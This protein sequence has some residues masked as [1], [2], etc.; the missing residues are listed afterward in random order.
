M[1]LVSLLTAFGVC[2]TGDRYPSVASANPPGAAIAGILGASA[3]KQGITVVV[4]TVPAQTG[5]R[6]RF[7]FVKF[8]QDGTPAGSVLIGEDGTLQFAHKTLFLEGQLTFGWVEAGK[9]IMIA[10]AQQETAS[11]KTLLVDDP[12]EGSIV[13]FWLGETEAQPQLFVRRCRYVDADGKPF[14][15]GPQYDWLYS[16]ALDNE[17]PRLRGKVCVE[18]AERRC[19]KMECAVSGDDVVVWQ[20]V[21]DSENSIEVI[22]C[23]QWRTDGR[24]A[25]KDRYAGNDVL[26]LLVDTSCGSVC[27]TKEWKNPEDA[28]G[29]LCCVRSNATEPVPVGSY[30]DRSP[31]VFVHFLRLPSLELWALTSKQEKHVGIVLLDND[32]QQR[33]T[34]QV[35]G[36]GI[37]D[38]AVATQLGDIHL[39][40]LQ[41]GSLVCKK[42]SV[43]H[44]QKTD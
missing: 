24:L 27:L 19:G 44:T 13:D 22:R 5:G 32:L 11:I 10:S 43:N 2:F 36:T 26:G 42:V 8:W 23:A 16:Y 35:D 34:L 3:S 14:A 31:G 20:T 37:T 28:S 30:G 40:L 4:P 33:E 38:Y 6:K 41:Q 29:I 25:W 17:E 21:C 18:N 1:L 9:G 39:I 12:N 15:A 7:W